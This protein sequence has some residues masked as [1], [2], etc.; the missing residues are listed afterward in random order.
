MGSR[1]LTMNTK[2]DWDTSSGQLSKCSGGWIICCTPFRLVGASSPTS[3]IPLTLNT[4]SPCVCR[5]RLNHSVNAVQSSTDEKEKEMDCTC[6]DTP[7]KY[8]RS[9]KL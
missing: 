6:E 9:G 4:F 5:R 2:N 8:W 3:N 7:L 1:F